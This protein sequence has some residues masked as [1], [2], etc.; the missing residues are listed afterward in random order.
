M[1]AG[2]AG[3]RPARRPA[4]RNEGGCMLKLARHLS[5][6]L[7]I[8]VL[9]ALPALAAHGE[10]ASG[11]VERWTSSVTD[12][13]GDLLDRLWSIGAATESGDGD[14][15]LLVDDD[16]AQPTPTLDAGETSNQLST[17]TGLAPTWDPGGAR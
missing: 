7:L 8:F 4:D 17:R 9:L 14:D 12:L 15:T 6:Y 3:M 5:G 13:L 1:K 11:A 10:P 16:D 2:G